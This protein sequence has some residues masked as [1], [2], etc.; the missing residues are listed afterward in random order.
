MKEVQNL[1]L[2]KYPETAADKFFIDRSRERN[3]IFTEEG[4]V[5]QSAW[6]TFHQGY[7]YEDFIIGLRPK[8]EAGAG[9]SLEAKAGVLLELAASTSNGCGLLLIDEI[10]RGNTSRIFGEFITLMEQDKRLLDDGTLG[11]KTVSVTLPYIGNGGE[12]TLESGVTIGR[13]FRMPY[14]FYT[15]ACM[16]S[17]DKSITPIDSAIRRRF[18][19]INLT[20]TRSDIEHCAGLSSASRHDVAKLAVEIFVKI[21]EGIGYFLGPDFVL[22]QYYLPSRYKLGQMEE[23]EAQSALVDLWCHRV[24]PQLVEL[25]QGRTE[26]LLSLLRFSNEKQKFGLQ[27]FMPEDQYLDEGAMPFVRFVS[28]TSTEAVFAELQSTFAPQVPLSA[29]QLEVAEAAPTD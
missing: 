12:I 10:N 6:I 18:H 25:F 20:P 19:V 27:V 22:G 13:E 8:P 21:N 23:H 29:D 11:E 17:V 1:F 4:R 3:A 5:G 14:R 2:S 24:L 15:L 7:S 26:A 28:I 16:N 9:F